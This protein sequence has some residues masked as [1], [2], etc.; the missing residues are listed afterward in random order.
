[1]AGQEFNIWKKQVF[2]QL[3]QVR[4][5]VGDVDFK[6]LKLD[7]ICRML[8]KLT[9]SHIPNQENFS[10]FKALTDKAIGSIPQEYV[11]KKN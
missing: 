3:D 4:K 1:M 9:P 5:Q 8:N 2:A 7:L 11:C 6:K 10:A